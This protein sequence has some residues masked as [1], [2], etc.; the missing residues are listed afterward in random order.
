MPVATSRR[1]QKLAREASS[2]IEED[3]GTQPS[4]RVEAHE[5]VDDDDAPAA[6]RKVKREGTGKKKA[7]GAAKHTELAP[8]NEDDDDEVIDIAHF[9]ANPR[10]L[11][12]QDCQKLN[13]LAGDWDGLIKPTFNTVSKSLEGAASGMADSQSTEVEVELSK[14]DSIMRGTIDVRALFNT[15]SQLLR[16]MVQQVTRGQEITDAKEHFETLRDEAKAK[17][18]AQTTRQKYAKNEEYLAFKQAIWEAQKPGEAMPPITDLLEAEGGDDSD[19]E[20]VVVGGV[21]QNFNCPIALTTLENP[22]TS[23]VCKH[24][25]SFVSLQ[26]FFNDVRGGMAKKCPT[27]GCSKSF[28]MAQC[29]ADS[30]LAKKIKDRERRLDA[31][32]AQKRAEEDD[33]DEVIE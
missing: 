32:A 28:T 31:A 27:A 18:D 26:S 8:D 25:F 3:N 24:S 15:Q 2:D 21:T 5:D 4:Q 7:K 33:D 6:S 10:P 14:L 19:D 9:S 20:D 23:T 30:A 11:A 29:Q 17:Y 12:R 1:K 16:D 13:A 22:Y